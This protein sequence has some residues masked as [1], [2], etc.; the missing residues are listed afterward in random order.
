MNIDKAQ[1]IDLLKSQG[2]ND[3]VDRAQSELPDQVDPEQH[4]DLLAKFGINPQ[5]LLGKIPG[6]G[7]FG[8]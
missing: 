1:I 4:S 2:K 6:L 5:D 8:G 3:D 7:G